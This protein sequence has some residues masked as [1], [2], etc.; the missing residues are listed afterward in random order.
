MPSRLEL[1]TQLENL[2][3]SRNVYFQPP[4]SLR[5]KYPAIVYTRD[6]IN[7]AFAGDEPYVSRRRYSVTVIDEDP[8]SLIIDKI[9]TLKNCQFNRHYTADQLH[10]DVFTL[11]Y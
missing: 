10:H 11:F 2:L 7:N 8:D 1:Q 9:N 4:E 6:G 5:M 3:G